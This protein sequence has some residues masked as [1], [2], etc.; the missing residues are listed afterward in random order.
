[1]DWKSVGVLKITHTG[2]EQ[3]FLLVNPSPSSVFKLTKRSDY[4]LE[5]IIYSFN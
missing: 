5:I 2:T 4:I 1:M 3:S